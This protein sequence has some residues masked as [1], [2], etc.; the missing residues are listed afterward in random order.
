MRLRLT[1]A[2]QPN[3]P[4]A[5][6]NSR[7]NL[8]TLAQRPTAQHAHSVHCTHHRSAWSLRE[9]PHRH[10]MADAAGFDA[11]GDDDGAGGDDDGAGGV[12]DTGGCDAPTFCAATF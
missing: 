12:D 9:R 7:I 11:G 2:W 6:M 8:A 10:T 5:A 4:G 1:H 3:M